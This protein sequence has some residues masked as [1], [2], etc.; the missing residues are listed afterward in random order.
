M[1]T[2]HIV[3]GVYRPHT[4][5]EENF[6]NDLSEILLNALLNNKTVILAGDMNINLLD[7]NDSSVN[8][9]NCMLN[10]LNYF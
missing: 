9:Y 4:D 8:Q 3:V 7:T 5:N 2:E 10:S 1:S 6:I